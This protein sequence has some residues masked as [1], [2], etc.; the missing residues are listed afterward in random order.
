MARWGVLLVTMPALAAVAAAQADLR[1]AE[2]EGRL[3]EFAAD[4]RLHLANEPIHATPPTRRDRIVKWAR[5][6]P[7]NSQASEKDPVFD[8]DGAEESR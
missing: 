1:W 7:G 5:R 8:P 6:N 2:R 4:L 3:Q